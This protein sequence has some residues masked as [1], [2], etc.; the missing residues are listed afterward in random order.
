MGSLQNMAYNRKLCNTTT[1]H[2]VHTKICIVFTQGH[3]KT[4]NSITV[5]T[6]RSQCRIVAGAT[7]LAL[8]GS[9][10]VENL[11]NEVGS[12]RRRRKLEDING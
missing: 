2:S 10:H 1:I 12:D 11:V 3:N 5:H 6:T 9:S 8:A 7:T 4:Y